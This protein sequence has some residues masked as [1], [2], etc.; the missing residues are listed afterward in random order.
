MIPAATLAG[1]CG[2]HWLLRT[3]GSGLVHELVPGAASVG[4]LINPK[5]PG[6]DL[7]M[8]EV[9]DAASTIKRQINFVHASTEAEI[10]AAISTLAQQGS[11]ALLVAQDPFFGGRREQLVALAAR[12]KLPAI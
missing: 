11:V 7:Q 12:Y 4:V 1:R 5:Y 6:F 9:Q 2:N 3:E 8:R 10:D